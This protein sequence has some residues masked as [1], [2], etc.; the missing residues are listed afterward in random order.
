M[1][2]L[3]DSSGLLR[4]LTA[5]ETRLLTEANEPFMAEGRFPMF[6]YIE[7]ILHRAELDAEALLRGLPTLGA[8]TLY[9]LVRPAGPQYW[10][11]EQ[12]V[13][14]TMAGLVQCPHAEEEVSVFL[15]V[16]QFLTERE[17]RIRPRPYEVSRLEVPSDQI[18]EHLRNAGVDFVPLAM[19]KVRVLLQYEPRDASSGVGG[20]EEEWIVT[21]SKDLRRYRGVKDARDYL[22][23]IAEGIAASSTPTKDP[24]YASPLQ[25]SEAIDYLDA[26]WQIR[27]KK[28]LFRLPNATA[29]VAL[30]LPCVSEDEFRMRV[31]A[32]TDVLARME[33]PGGMDD[34]HAQG[35]SL[36]RL[37]GF[38]RANADAA[39]E[40]RVKE[41][42]SS[43]KGI[44]AI[45]A[46][47]QHADARRREVSAYS[48]LG[49]PYPPQGWTGAWETV[50]AR[51]V[52]AFNAIREELQRNSPV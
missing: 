3:L 14:L 5:D 36:G 27:F 34:R 4:R 51:A 17:E 9:G 38:L 49:I 12:S 37:T 45:R 50:Q 52:E 16:L 11:A 28:K 10:R 48:L 24:E 8:H 13:E 1:P 26:V 32:L 31:S 7:R 35:A 25:L 21:A 15:S 18:A 29:I 42:I 44:A 6:D 43:L 30:S 23:R 20:T 19:K 40:S 33:I 41:A 39:S 22:E 2:T 47:A 46:G